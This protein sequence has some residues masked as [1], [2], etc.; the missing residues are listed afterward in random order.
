MVDEDG[1]GA[2]HEGFESRSK[3]Q[4][5]DGRLGYAVGR[6]DQLLDNRSHAQDK[7]IEQMVGIQLLYPVDVDRVVLR[8][9]VGKI[10]VLKGEGLAGIGALLV[11]GLV[12]RIFEVP[13]FDLVYV[14]LV[15]SHVANRQRLLVQIYLK[16][17]KVF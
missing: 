3:G 10:G 1:V 8:T 13:S 9:L 5:K 11:E 12:L 15:S 7:L 2:F 6:F 14:D 16:V 4:Q 17:Q